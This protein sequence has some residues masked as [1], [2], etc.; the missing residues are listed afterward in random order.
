MGHDDV[1]TIHSP[2]SSTKYL[3]LCLILCAI[4]PTISHWGQRVLI[5]GDK[6]SAKSTAARGLARLLP[7]IE[8]GYDSSL[9]AEE[10]REMTTT[11]MRKEQKI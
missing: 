8:V 9:G 7:K 3:M 1:G 4:D 6:G 5:R 11:T 10:L 2:Q